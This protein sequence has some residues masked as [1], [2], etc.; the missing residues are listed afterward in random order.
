MDRQKWRNKYVFCVWLLIASTFSFPTSSATRCLDK[1]DD[2]DMH[3]GAKN[4]EWIKKGAPIRVEIGPRDVEK[5]SV[6]VARRD[7]PHKEKQ[8]IEA[9]EFLEEVGN[10]LQQI[11][12]NLLE[13]A[14]EFRDANMQKIDSM[15]EFIKFFTPSNTEK[16]EIHGGFALCHWAGSNEEE[17]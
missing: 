12:S 16:P 8:F 2:R 13:E 14:T 6:A 11:Q 3:G 9:Q 4:W 15:E 5:G 10:I 1:V 17:E 7:K